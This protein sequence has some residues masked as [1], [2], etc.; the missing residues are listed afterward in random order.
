MSETAITEVKETASNQNPKGGC[1]GSDHATEAYAD[2]GNATKQADRRTQTPS[3]SK[4]ACCCGSV[5]S[6]DAR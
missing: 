2:T 1:C 3:A 6:K 5:S 4:G